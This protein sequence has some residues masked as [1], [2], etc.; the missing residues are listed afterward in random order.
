MQTSWR[1]PTGYQGGSSPSTRGSQ[2][3]LATEIALLS[4]RLQQEHAE[5]RDRLHRLPELT[6]SQT[7]LAMQK[8]GVPLNRQQG[9]KPMG[10]F[11][12]ILLL[13]RSSTKLVLALRSL[14]I[15]SLLWSAIGTGAYNAQ[16]IGTQ[17][18]LAIRESV[19]ALLTTG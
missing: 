13:F 11:S 5:L 10:Y 8:Y 17:I 1:H 14:L 4:E 18:G 2:H 15:L 9:R 6:A 16:E 3:S 19:K 12:K 7:V